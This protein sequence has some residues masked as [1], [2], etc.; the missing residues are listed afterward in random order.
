MLT[1]VD[2]L[3][4]LKTA[5]N[6]ALDSEFLRIVIGKQQKTYII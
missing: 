5:K 6:W 3:T 2:M 1:H 4:I